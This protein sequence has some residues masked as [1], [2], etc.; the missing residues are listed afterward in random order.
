MEPPLVVKV[1]IAGQVYACIRK[2]P[3]NQFIITTG[4]RYSKLWSILIYLIS[5]ILPGKDD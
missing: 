2:S 5:D 4:S 1:R 3:I